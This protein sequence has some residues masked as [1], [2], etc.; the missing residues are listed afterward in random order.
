MIKFFRKIRQKLLS[1]N[2]FSKYLLYAIG[3]II[4]V[5]IGILLALQLNYLK[6]KRNI[7]KQ[8]R[9]ALELIKDNL[10]KEIADLDRF[11]HQRVR[12]TT[13]LKNVYYKKWNGIPLDSLGMKGTSAFNYKPFNT[14]YEGLK[15]NDKLFIIQNEELKQKIIFY[16]EQQRANL[17]DW[18]DW[19]RSFV[20]DVLEKYMFTELPINPNELIDDLNFLKA[21]LEDRQLKSLISNQIG[22]LRRLD[23]TISEAKNYAYEIIE[24]I[25]KEIQERW[26]VSN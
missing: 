7:L 18:S 17:L 21:K 16:F 5:V 9:N 20:Y 4:L 22:S 8:E 10:Q 6:E 3:E 24:L 25:D 12:D 13:Y 26:A 11:V 15:A 14:A 23:R 2:K 19:H 1:E